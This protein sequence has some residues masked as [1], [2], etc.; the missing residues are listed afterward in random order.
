[1]GFGNTVK[2][3]QMTLGLV[4]EVLDAVDVVFTGGKQL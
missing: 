2:F 1:M 4:P 3:A